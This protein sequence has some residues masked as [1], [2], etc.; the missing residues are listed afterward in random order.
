MVQSESPANGCLLPL[1]SDASWAVD[2][3]NRRISNW[4]LR[5]APMT[6]GRADDCDVLIRDPSVSRHHAVLTWDA[7]RLLL[8]HLSN[9][10]PTLLN[11]IPVR[12]NE[13]TEL[14]STDKLQIGGVH[15]EVL[16]WNAASDAETK[17]H[18]PPR[19]LAVVLAADVV[20]FTRL[21]QRDQA[22]TLQLFEECHRVFR[23][24]AQR[25]R[26][27]VLDTGEKGDCVYSLYHSVLLGLSAA[28]A[29]RSEIVALNRDVPA[30][31]RITFRY[32]VHSGDV[33]LQ[34]QGIRG[35]AINTAA[36]LQAKAQPG[37]IFVSARIQQEASEQMGF[38]F[39]A[40]HGAGGSEIIAYR[41]VSAPAA[42]GGVP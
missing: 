35:D 12:L 13:A 42:D 5:A 1:P 38:S 19:T 10:N 24:Q 20:G 32:G 15:F 7:H 40:V 6:I 25:N 26:G 37:E 11:G 33:V 17:P 16:L 21:W 30:D 3:N 8:T 4:K 9:T 14:T 36:H 2:R 23:R 39:E 31:R 34:G 29:I 28:I 18:P 27:R 22:G 41:L